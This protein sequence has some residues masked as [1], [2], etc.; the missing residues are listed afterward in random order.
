MSRMDKKELIDRY[1]YDV[2]RRLPEKMRQ[3]IGEELRTLIEDMAED[4]DIEDV[5]EEL[6]DPTILARKYRGDSG[7]LISGVYYDSYWFFIKIILACAAVGLLI[8]D[9]VS[10]FVRVVGSV[11]RI[12]EDGRQFFGEVFRGFGAEFM[13][14]GFGDSGWAGGFGFLGSTLAVL[15]NLF[16]VITI[17]FIILEKYQ[18]GMRDFTAE[19]MNQK[20]NESKNRDKKKT[21]ADKSYDAASDTANGKS[22]GQSS[23]DVG[24]LPPIPVQTSVIHKSSMIS[25]IVFSMIGVIILVAVPHWLGVWTS[26]LEG[27]GTYSVIPV[28]NMEVWGRILPLLLTAA[29]LG[30]MKSIVKLVQGCYN[31]SVMIVTAVLN[32][33]SISIYYVAFIRH[34]IWNPNF[35]SMLEEVFQREFSASGDI[36]SY[37]NTPFF[38]SLIFA[39]FA[40]GLIIETITVAY[41]ALRN[42]M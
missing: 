9:I 39:L 8:S 7:S 18:V 26:A 2:T 14:V 25:E 20:T 6:G 16:A 38:S 3:D 34:P 23:W 40:F 32:F 27:D 13:G 1:V 19:A 4:K 33:V 36:I 37:W 12:G 21:K 11:D 5:L 41:R 28:F 30:M 22:A 24:K 35:R 15:L 42:R 29:F 17:V 10:G 31:I